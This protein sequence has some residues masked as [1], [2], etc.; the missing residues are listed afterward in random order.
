MPS[1]R[2]W[3]ALCFSVAVGAGGGLGW[4]HVEPPLGRWIQKLVPPLAWVQVSV[5]SVGA[6]LL[7]AGLCLFISGALGGRARIQRR[8]AV[9]LWVA[10]AV[11][12]GT[13]AQSLASQ[14][15]AHGLGMRALFDP[16]LAAPIFVLPPL[17]VMA[18]LLERSTVGKDAER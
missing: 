12:A 3:V 6:T 1:L 2:P 18:A 15:A 16:D 14:V 9:C 17:T 4:A 13:L 10:S 5:L 11:V 7:L 8:A